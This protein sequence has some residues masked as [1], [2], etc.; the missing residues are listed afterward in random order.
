MKVINIAT[1]VLASCVDNSTEIQAL[2]RRLAKHDNLHN[3]GRKERLLHPVPENK[4][5]GARSL[6][7]LKLR[8]QHTS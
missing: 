3:K 4:M 1:S 2:C 8:S 6:K 5:P 7:Q